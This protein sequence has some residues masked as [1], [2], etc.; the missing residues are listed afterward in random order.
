M[1]FVND[2]YVVVNSDI[3]VAKAVDVT[4]EYF[5]CRAIVGCVYFTHC[6]IDMVIFFYLVENYF[7]FLPCGICVAIV[8]IVLHVD[9][10]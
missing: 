4:L 3:Y 9:N 8:F 2:I 7:C 5:H 1:V 10:R 6:D